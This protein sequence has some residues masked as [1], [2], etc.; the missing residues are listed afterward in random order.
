[1]KLYL[2]EDLSPRIADRLHMMGWDAVSA[3]EVG[4][5]QCSDWEQLA[6][7]ARERRSLVT[8]NGRHFLVLAGDA[9]RRQEPHAGIIVCPPSI[10]GSEVSEI[11]SRLLRLAKRYPA[12]LGE[13]DLVYL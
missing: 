1:M 10:R 3:I 6:Y 12:G 7:A 8:R 2:D 11:V 5:V 4:N 13:Y 9:V